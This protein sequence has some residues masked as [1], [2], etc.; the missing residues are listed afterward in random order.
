MRLSCAKYVSQIHSRSKDFELTTNQKKFVKSINNRKLVF[1]DGPAGS[2]KTLLSCRHAIEK[3]NS[4][5]VKNVV[6]TRPAISIHNEQHG[7]L[8]GD[9]NAKMGV[10]VAPLLENFMLF[11]SE[12][13]VNQYINNGNISIVPLAYIRGLTFED[14]IVIGDEMQNSSKEQMLAL[15]T[16][17]GQNCQMIITGDGNQSDVLELGIKNGLKDFIDKYEES[18]DQCEDIEVVKFTD[19]DIKRSELIKFISEMYSR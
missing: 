5:E 11:E 7:F 15:L 18:E 1:L 17:I 3:L 8:P 12:R 2:G 4:S 9:L 6:I 14:S 10:W 16:R 13:K 19:D